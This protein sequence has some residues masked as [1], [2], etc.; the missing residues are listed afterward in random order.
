MINRPLVLPPNIMKNPL[1]YAG[2]L[3]ALMVCSLS[4]VS[5]ANLTWTTDGSGNWGNGAGGW[6]SNGVGVN[7][8]NATP[9]TATIGKGGTAGTISLTSAITTSAITFNTV[10]GTYTLGGSGVLT[11]TGSAVITVNDDAAVLTNQT[12]GTAGLTKVGSGTLFMQSSND[13]TYSGTTS[14]TEGTLALGGAGISNSTRIV[15]GGGANAAAFQM[16]ANGRLTANTLT[17]INNNGVFIMNTS[18][19]NPNNTGSFLINSGGNMIA[20]SAQTVNMDSG[21]LTLNNG[22]SLTGLA[23]NLTYNLG[24]TNAVSITGTSASASTVAAKFSLVNS[25][26]IFTVDDVVSGTG[27]DAIISGSIGGSGA[28]TKAGLGT[29]SLTGTNGYSGQTKVNAGALRVS[30]SLSIGTANLFLNGGVIELGYDLLRTNTNSQS[31]ANS[32]TVNVQTGGGFGAVGGDRIVAF[33][34]TTM[35]TSVSWS[36][37]FGAGNGIDTLVF[38]SASSDGMVDFRNNLSLSSGTRNIRVDNGAAAVD[39]RM[40]GTLSN[41]TVRKQGL[42]ALE[43]TG[44]NTNVDFIVAAGALRINTINN[45]SSQGVLGNTSNAVVLGSSGTAGTL[46]YAGS[47]ASSTKRFTMATS[48]TGI[49]DVANS[50]ANLTLG[51]VIDGSGGMHKIGSGTLTLSGANTFGGAMSI[52]QGVVSIGSINNASA[53]GVLGNSANSVTMGD[54]NTAATLQYTGATA[55]SNKGFLMAASGTGVFDVTTAATNL[56]L[57]GSIGGTGGLTKVGSG[58]LTLSNSA[59]NYTGATVVAGGVLAYGAS[60]VIG[61]GAVT[62]HGPTAVLALGANSDSVGTVTVDNGGSITG[63]GGSLTSTGSF[64]MRSGSVSAALAG[65]GIGLNKTTTGTVSLSG[66]NTYSGATSVTAGTLLVTNTGRLASSGVTVDAGA[67]F[68]YNNNADAYSGNVTANGTVGGTGRI[69]GVISG[70]GQVG[71]GNS[72][73]VLA[74]AAV[75]GATGL[76]FNFEFTGTG[77]P[78]YGNNT[79]SINDVLRLT[80]ASAPFT[81]PLD[82]SNVINIYLNVASLNQGDVFYGGFYTDRNTSFLSSISGATYQFYLFNAGGG[83][84]YNGV[85]Y[86]PYSGPP[87]IQIGVVAQT[88][89]FGGSDIDGY[90][91]EVSVIPE[92]STSLLAGVGFAIM[93]SGCRRGRRLRGDLE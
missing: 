50:A 40:S 59:N 15:V 24:I 93:L 29:L 60:N 23:S 10:T 3:V 69:N 27:V 67:T 12:I 41:G 5:A 66:T 17:T 68:I 72:P 44:S 56:T 36:D 62:V 25:E 45:A 52:R 2:P 83:I 34:G 78:A 33:G 76:G 31:G 64:E 92:P 6:T 79:A 82:G 77:A 20:N 91:M 90:V 30:G 48:G 8:N 32:V 11:L 57:S 73:G 13:F 87:S 49:F 47:T 81:A 55:T 4:S 7:W 9:D 58:S 71:P 14:V 21:T 54:T 88:A 42:G 74:A 65:S 28:F 63:S 86:D 80:D 85:N 46:I 89:N 19:V 38:S 37:F 26:R 43:V 51:G 84:T 61:T 75:V 22:G 39:A 53:N 16:N 35:P 18:I 70:S 1:R